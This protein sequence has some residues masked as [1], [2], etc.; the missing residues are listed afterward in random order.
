ME[1]GH[2]LDGSAL[3][4]VTTT[5]TYNTTGD[6]KEVV[7]ETTGTALGLSQ[8]F[9][10]INTNEYEP[11]K[12]DGDQWILGRLKSSKVRSIAPNSLGSIATSAGTSP[13]AGDRSGSG[14]VPRLDPA[15]LNVI[16][17]LLLDD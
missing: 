3:P 1:T 9:R 15:V 14:S 16:L 17:Q 4:T 2:D 10:K 5:H 13:T 8:T 6:L 7:T 12:T 11:D